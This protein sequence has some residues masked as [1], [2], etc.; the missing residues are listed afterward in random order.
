MGRGTR[1]VVVSKELCS[2]P[3]PNNY[4]PQRNNK[5][6]DAQVR[7][8]SKV[9][10]KQ[11]KPKD[12]NERRKK[13]RPNM[14]EDL[15]VRQAPPVIYAG[16][17]G[18]DENGVDLEN[19]QTV[20][21]L[22]MDERDK[23][24]ISDDPGPG[25]HE[26]KSKIGSGPAFKMGGPE[27]DTK[28]DRD[29]TGPSSYNAVVKS[30]APKYSF[31]GRPSI[32]LGFRNRG[33][34]KSKRP[35]PGEYENNDV[36]FKKPTTKFSKAAKNTFT[37]MSGPLP[38]A[39]FDPQPAKYESDKYSFPYAKR[40]DDSGRDRNARMPGPGEYQIVDHLPKGQS[41]SMLGGPIDPPKTKDSGVPGPGNYFVE[42]NDSDYLNHIP[43]V[44]IVKKPDRFS[45]K[46]DDAENE[47][48]RDYKPKQPS[49]MPRENVK[50]WGIGK[51]LR[52]PIKNK[53]ETPA[54][55]AY[56][57]V[58][59]PPTGD[60][61]EDDKNKDKKYK[62]HM[63]MRTNYK[64]NRGQ[65]VPG[66]A[67][68][69]PDIWQPNTIAHVIGTGARSDLGVGKAYLAPGPGEYE[70]RGR[71]EGP[72]IKFGN[73]IKNTKI[74]KTYEPGPANYEIAGTVGNIPKY[75][76]LKQE[77]DEAE[78]YDDKSENIELL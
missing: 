57:V 22:G 55:N 2:Y 37:K 18:L 33:N 64:A 66:P 1:S 4:S 78:R 13:D 39:E 38:A 12:R 42:T 58:D 32:T 6:Q 67:D 25:T 29:Q 69:V 73:E 43:G 53:F 48:A 70:V 71:I 62:F 21:T 17:D 75:L 8:R 31:G 49:V 41:K 28:V 26:I 34:M 40:F 74:K 27:K 50:G 72:Q 65:E 24:K 11:S 19:I 3:A 56:E 46:I 59:F 51:G 35:G 45:N 23:R 9:A 14:E 47:R 10:I 60:K 30:R 77:R 15:R 63:G 68:Y 16:G 44:R 5:I 36:Q 52:D 54:P 76:R 7:Q 20:Y 61:K